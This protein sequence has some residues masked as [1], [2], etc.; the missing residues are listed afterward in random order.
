M[1]NTWCLF[2]GTA[3]PSLATSIARVLQTPLS[4]CAIERFPDGEVSVRLDESVRGREVFIIQPTS[5]PVDEHVMELLIFA[6]ACRR[7][8]AG[9]ITAVVP[10]FGYARQDRRRGRRE[11]ITASMVAVLMQ[12]IG[13][14]Q[15]MVI[16]VH[17]E[18]VEGFFLVPMDTLTAVSVLC[19][20]LQPALPTGTIVVSP[21]AGRVGMATDYAQRLGT[22]VAVL[23]KHRESGT[24]TTVTHVVGD[25]A[26][27]PCLIIDDMISTGGTI[28]RSIEA[29]LAA[30]AAPDVTVAATHGLFVGRARELLSGPPIR[31][32]Y[33]TDTVPVAAAGWERLHVVSV[34]PLLAAAIQQVIAGGSVSRLRASSGIPMP[35]APRTAMP[36]V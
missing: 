31:G 15:V 20:A 13:I 2:A 29:L 5:P 32:V 19:E 14:D 23:H 7:A 17:A 21:D 8:A 36:P 26:G 10:Y 30:G 12:T 18:Q 33:V 4:P 3:N 6:D 22:S 25:V 16:D 11:P 24:A 35:S 27:R 9:R 34:A 28:A 1:T